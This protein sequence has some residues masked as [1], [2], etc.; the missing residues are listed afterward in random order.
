MLLLD[1]V[2]YLFLITCT[3]PVTELE[4][5]AGIADMSVIPRNY[6]ESILQCLLKN[7]NSLNTDL[8]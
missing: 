6:T 7:L 4:M 8:T 3:Y 5:H 1:N 2:S